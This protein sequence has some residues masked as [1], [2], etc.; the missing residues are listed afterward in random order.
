MDW[1][2]MDS[3][4]YGR[5]QQTA[6]L[7]TTDDGQAVAPGAMAGQL[8]MFAEQAPVWVQT[9]QHTGCVLTSQHEHGMT[10]AAMEA[11]FARANGH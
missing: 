7:L 1:T 4:Q 10:D 6:L 9:C 11:L 2:Q 8:D 3:R 5:A